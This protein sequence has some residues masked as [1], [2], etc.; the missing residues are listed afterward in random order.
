[1]AGLRQNSFNNWPTPV[2]TPEKQAHTPYLVPNWILMKEI[3]LIQTS[4]CAS[5]EQY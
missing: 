2:L 3:K 1:M 4:L 5:T